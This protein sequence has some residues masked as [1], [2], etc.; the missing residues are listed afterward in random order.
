MA[1]YL[2]SFGITR[3]LYILPRVKQSQKRFN[4]LQQQ[5]NTAK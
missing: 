3:K 5:G 2:S 1:R 4:M